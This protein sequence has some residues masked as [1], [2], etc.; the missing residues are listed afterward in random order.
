MN[1]KTLKDILMEWQRRLDL[2]DWEIEVQVVYLL[3]G[4]RAEL[5]VVDPEGKYALLE[6]SRQC[7]REQVESALLHELLEL[8]FEPAH[9]IIYLN[10]SEND[11]GR[12]LGERAR[13]MNHLTACLLRLKGNSEGKEKR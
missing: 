5:E 6:V 11:L 2:L 7:P 10:L 1:P 12:W 8:V 3:P 4:N 13:A 9:N